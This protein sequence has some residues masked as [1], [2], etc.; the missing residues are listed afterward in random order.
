ML[1]LPSSKCRSK[2]H[3]GWEA[4]AQSAADRYERRYGYQMQVYLCD[5]CGEWHI[6]KRMHFGLPVVLI[7]YL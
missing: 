7:E 5:E 4:K 3:Y 6:K 1:P 2:N